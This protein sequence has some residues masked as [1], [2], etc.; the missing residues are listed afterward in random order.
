MSAAIAEIDVISLIRPLLVSKNLSAAPKASFA[1]SL[2]RCASTAQQESLCDEP[3]VQFSITDA[4]F[5]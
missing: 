4:V 1:E 3:Y 2:V 5:N